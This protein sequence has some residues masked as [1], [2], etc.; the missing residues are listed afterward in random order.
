MAGFCKGGGGGR[1]GGERARRGRGGRNRSRGAA[2]GAL[3]LKHTHRDALD[4]VAQD[5][6]VALGAALA[7]TLAT[8]AA[9]GHFG[10]CLRVKVCE[11]G[12]AGVG[13]H[14]PSTSTAEGKSGVA[15]GTV[16]G[17][18]RCSGVAQL[19]HTQQQ[20]ARPKQTARKSTGG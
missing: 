5:L 4:V 13:G 20:M 1:G 17:A 10:M 8:L 9:T 19:P 11:R 16:D 12:A 14:R 18:S 7:Q 3:P 6:A 15:P 2:E